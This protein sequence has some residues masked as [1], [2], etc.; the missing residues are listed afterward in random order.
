MDPILLIL[1]GLLTVFF[2]ALWFVRKCVSAAVYFL[3]MPCLIVT[4]S[5]AGAL[6]L[7]RIYWGYWT[8][9]PEPPFVT[10]AFDGQGERATAIGSF[11]MKSKTGKRL[12]PQELPKPDASRPTE[13]PLEHAVYWVRYWLAPD[14][15]AVGNLTPAEARVIRNMPNDPVWHVRDERGYHSRSWMRGV[16]VRITAA[17]SK[18]YLFVAAD[19]DEISDDHHPHYRALYEYRPDGSLKLASRQLMFYD[20][21][22]MEGAT[23]ER[24]FLGLCVVGLVIGIP[25]AIL[26][27]SLAPLYAALRR[28]SGRG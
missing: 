18:R 19:G 17:N 21:A 9:P 5:L 13:D 8:S 6:S 28:R 16:W 23:W 2:A 1:L 27:Y 14:A 24:I 10:M 26:Y 4:L 20:V 7:S 22:G 11:E 25:S 3:F 15:K 12:L